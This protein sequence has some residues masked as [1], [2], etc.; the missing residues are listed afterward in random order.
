MD[1]R[2]LCGTGLCSYA[3]DL[4]DL[5]DDNLKDVIPREIDFLEE[6]EWTLADSHLQDLFR[7]MVHNHRVDHLRSWNIGVRETGEVCPLH[8]FKSHRLHD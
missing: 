7:R 3:I 4:L 1:F 2:W 6:Q 8:F 5:S